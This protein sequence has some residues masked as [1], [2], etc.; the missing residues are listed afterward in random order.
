MGQV[1]YRKVRW[2]VQSHTASEWQTQGS[3]L[4][5]SALRSTWLCIKSQKMFFLWHNN[6]S[7]AF[8]LR[9]SFKT[10]RAGGTICLKIFITSNGKTLGVTDCPLTRKMA[11]SLGYTRLVLPRTIMGSPPPPPTE[12]RHGS[13][14]WETS[15]NEIGKAPP[16]RHV[17]GGELLKMGIKNT[18]CGKKSLP[19]MKKATRKLP[20]GL[21]AAMSK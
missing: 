1:G 2:F 4:G 10:W 9:V 11:N 7:L 14:C 18:R 19:Y 6:S 17:L 13:T 8:A 12:C 3:S 20:C 16:L 15:G 21:F 5:N